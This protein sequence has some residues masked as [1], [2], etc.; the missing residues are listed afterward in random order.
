MIRDLIRMTMYSVAL[1]GLSSCSEGP[2]QLSEKPPR[3]ASSAP[4]PAI[5]SSV[6]VSTVIKYS[7][8]SDLISQAL[9]KQFANNG[10]QKVCVDVNETVQNTVQNGVGGDV[11][12]FLGGVARLVTTVVTVNQLRHVCQDIDYSVTVNR[13]DVARVAPNGNS[14]RISVPI[15]VDGWAGFSGDLAKVVALD[16]KSFRGSITAFVDVSIDIGTDWCPTIQA[17][18]DFVW[19]DKAKLKVAGRFWIDINRTVGPKLKDTMRDAA[20]KLTSA[21][22]CDQ[23]KAAVKPM[24]H[25]YSIP[26]ETIKDQRE[27][28]NL[29]P[30]SIGFSGLTFEPGAVRTAFQLVTTNEV[31][32]TAASMATLSLPEL[33]KIPAQSNTLSL[34]LPM[35]ADYRDLRAVAVALLSNNTFESDT[36]VGHASVKI[37]D[38]EVYPAGANLVVGLKFQATLNNKMLDTKGWVYLIAEPWLDPSA[39]TLRLRNVRF[40]RDLDNKIWS[41]LATIFQGEIQAIIE[42]KS[43]VDLKAY[44]GVLRSY[45]QEQLKT[46]G[47]EQGIELALEDTFFGIKQINLTDKE[48]EILVGFNG[49]ANLEIER[50]IWLPVAGSR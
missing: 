14:L 33:T 17:V 8:I 3:S 22:T 5:S 46:V 43:V 19:R 1:A 16:K 24:W 6:S 49:T 42:E 18:P 26:I 44:V 20:K 47:Q 39:Q 11:G 50:A 4:I 10:R 7:A 9:P 12:R 13:D 15:S 48:M 35:R 28:V 31:S 36:P 34:V 2:A 23:I 41:V 27:Y 25:V 45:L 21:I 40:T 32:S 38:A 30:K 37:F 29:V